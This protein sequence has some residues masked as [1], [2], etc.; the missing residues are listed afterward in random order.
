[1]VFSG[2]GWCTMRMRTPAQFRF[3]INLRGTDPAAVPN[4]ARAAE[5]A[6]FDVLYAADHLGSYDPFAALTCAA[7]ATTRIRLGT[8]VLNNEF[9]NPA[10][11]ARAVASV[12][13]ISDGR[14]ELG[15][16]CGYMKSEFD[17]AGIPW[18]PHRQRVQ[19]LAAS[20]DELDPHFAPGGLEP[21]PLQQPRPPLLI[22]AHGPAT[23]ELAARYADIVGYSGLTQ[24][25]DAE[26]GN[27]RVAGSEETLE[28]VELVSQLAAERVREL[29]FNVLIQHVEI[30]DDAEGAA[31]ALVERFHRAGLVSA[32]DVLDTPFILVGTAQEIANEILTARDRYGFTNIVTHGAF[33]DALAQVIP[34]VR[35]D[36][37]ERRAS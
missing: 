8:L 29:E 20:L 36:A 26:P 9:W 6:G 24:R 13:R 21:T 22:G 2:P 18:R 4:A 12:D 1:M 15:L 31:A 37:D 23:L 35:R 32:R 27:F 17:T 14:F 28:R 30:T 19:N 33:R 34:L 11:L 16:G 5:D 7:A 25:R 10:L 3:G